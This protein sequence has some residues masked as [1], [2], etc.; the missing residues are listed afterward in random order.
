MSAV[1][2]VHVDRSHPTR[3]LS[4][5]NG[6]RLLMHDAAVLPELLLL[7][8]RL[9]PPDLLSVPQRCGAWV[10]R[11]VSTETADKAL[12]GNSHYPLETPRCLTYLEQAVRMVQGDA[13]GPASTGSRRSRYG[14]RSSLQGSLKGAGRA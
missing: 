8:E 11:L 12:V 13:G 3:D 1:S 14:K 10:L 7:Q 2:A 4:R 9:I 6:H 5:G